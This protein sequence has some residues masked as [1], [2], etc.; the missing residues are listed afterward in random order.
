MTRLVASL[1]VVLAACANGSADAPA[2]TV[3]TASERVTIFTHCGFHET[4]FDGTVWTPA[5]I[6]RGDFPAGTDS[7]ATPGVMTRVGD[8]AR[9]LADSDLEVWFELAPANLPPPPPCD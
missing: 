5:S 3:P 4:T 6:E 1:L 8:R 9:F 2:T 7:M